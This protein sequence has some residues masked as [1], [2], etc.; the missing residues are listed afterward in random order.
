MTEPMIPLVDATLGLDVWFPRA[1]EPHAQRLMDALGV[2][3]HV[4]PPVRSTGNAS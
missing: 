1:L 3:V 4:D 2:V